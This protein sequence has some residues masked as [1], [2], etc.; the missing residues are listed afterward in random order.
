MD[1]TFDRLNGFSLDQDFS[2]ND[3]MKN[4]FGDT[5]NSKN[6]GDLSTF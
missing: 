6:K 1:Q 2:G 5:F 4:D 3:R